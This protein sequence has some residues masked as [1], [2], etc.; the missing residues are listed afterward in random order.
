[1][2]LDI[3]NTILSELSNVPSSAKILEVQKWIHTQ[4][5]KS[6]INNI[7]IVPMWIWRSN[8]EWIFPS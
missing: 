7:R 6:K 4:W 8:D 5:R 3:K 2:S 1:M